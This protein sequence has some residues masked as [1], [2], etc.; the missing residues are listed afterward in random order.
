MIRRIIRLLDRIVYGEKVLNT[1]MSV[2]TD[3]QGRYRTCHK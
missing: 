2:I 3:D 1:R